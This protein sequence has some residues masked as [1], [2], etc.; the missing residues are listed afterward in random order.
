MYRNFIR[1]K[2]SEPQWQQAQGRTKRTTQDEDAV[3]KAELAD[4]K[5]SY[6]SESIYGMQ[7]FGKAGPGSTGSVD[8]FVCALA[9]E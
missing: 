5:G 4:T 7:L 9:S 3:A 6:H 1:T 2:P 8:M